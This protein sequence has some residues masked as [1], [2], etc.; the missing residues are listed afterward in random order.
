M[1]DIHLNSSLIVFAV[2]VSK[3]GRLLIKKNLTIDK[4]F[5]GC[6]WS[7]KKRNSYKKI[8]I[9]KKSTNLS[10]SLWDGQQ[11]IEGEK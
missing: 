6:I 1:Y 7:P 9:Y 11:R 2:V 3:F 5:F 8:F 10:T 4:Y